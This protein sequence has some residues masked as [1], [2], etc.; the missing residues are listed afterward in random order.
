MSTQMQAAREG[1]LTAAMRAGFRLRP[2]R[3]RATPLRSTLSL[4]R[5]HSIPGSTLTMEHAL[6]FPRARSSRR[7]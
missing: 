5:N 4:H 6:D 7:I 2:W 1:V 3:T